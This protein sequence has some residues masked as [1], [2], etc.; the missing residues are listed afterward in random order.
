[1]S[2]YQIDLHVHTRDS[3]DGCSSL[4]ELAAAAKA[5]G[6]D[7]I[8]VTDHNLCTR[9]PGSLEGVLL[10][11]GCEISTPVG[12]ITGLFLRRPVD[13]QI[14]RALPDPETAVE[15]IRDAGGIAVLAHPF[16]RSGAE[17]ALFSFSMDGVE[18]ANARAGL[19]VKD[20]NK[21]AERFAAERGLT[22]IGGSDAHHADEVGNA[23]TLVECEGCSVEELRQA[24]L[25][26][27]TTAVLQ[28]AAT[29][30]QKGRS[31]WVK[32]C[33]SRSPYRI[34]KGAAY[35]CCCILR[36]LRRR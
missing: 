6:L 21:K 7:G 36:D 8:A 33:R 9:C 2:I 10:I 4:E 13:P 5:R 16:Q 15:A 31:Q 29:H 26:G 18:T 11:P 35:W 34:C 32:A 12:H 14:L 19:K 28:R 30:R 27:R 1:M 20:A 3:A 24:V 22:A 23:F 17:K 25:E